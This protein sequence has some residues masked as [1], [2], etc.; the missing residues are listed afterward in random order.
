MAVQRRWIPNNLNLGDRAM[1]GKAEEIKGR[2]KEAAGALADDDNLRR[3]GQVDQAAGKV[4]QAVG[5][6]VDKTKAALDGLKK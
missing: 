1:A 4:K 3:E 5:K 2:V 6:A